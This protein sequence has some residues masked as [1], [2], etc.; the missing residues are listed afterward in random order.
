MKGLDHNDRK[1][2]DSSI[3][4]LANNGDFQNFMAAI[5]EEYETSIERL[6]KEEGRDKTKI[7][8][9]YTQS[10]KHIIDIFEEA[11]KR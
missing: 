5:R 8:Q 7:L 11:V 2:I 4:S 9:G 10:H 6:I 3:Q 1:I